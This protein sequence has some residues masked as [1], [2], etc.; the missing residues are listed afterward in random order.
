MAVD[1]NN[2][3]DVVLLISVSSAT[4]TGIFYNPGWWG[5]WGWY[6]GWGGSYPGYGMG[7][8]GGYP[9][10]YSYSTGSVFM[11]MV[12]PSMIDTENETFGVV[13]LATI[14]GLLKS[15]GSTG[16]TRVSEGINQAF[17]QSEDILKK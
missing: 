6:P 8:P 13:W 5:Y 14:N 7:Y 1:T 15:S 17:K 16:G 4:N 2:L 3:S 12:D 10:G 9:L 11:T